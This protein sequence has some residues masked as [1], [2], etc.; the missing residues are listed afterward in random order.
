MQ[1]RQ[2]A[3]AVGH[4]QQLV[5]Q[6]AQEQLLTATFGEASRVSVSQYARRNSEPPSQ[7]ADPLRAEM[8]RQQ[9]SYLEQIARCRDE[10]QTLK[11]ALRQ[12][13]ERNRRLQQLLRGDF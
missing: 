9:Q 11:S 2:A 6:E 5:H 10:I 7:G 1:Q 8:E 4:R 13:L 12:E 3:R